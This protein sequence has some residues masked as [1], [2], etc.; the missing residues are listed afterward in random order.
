MVLLSF[1]CLSKQSD[2]TDPRSDN[3]MQFELDLC[4]HRK[5]KVLKTFM[6]SS[7]IV[8]AISEIPLFYEHAFYYSKDA[9]SMFAILFFFRNKCAI[10]AFFSFCYACR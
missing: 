9:A 5:L 10:V 3:P 4:R 8:Q 6:L 7:Q 1:I 2:G